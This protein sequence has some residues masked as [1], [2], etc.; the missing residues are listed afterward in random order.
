VIVVNKW[1][2]LKGTGTSTTE[3]AEKIRAELKFAPYASIVF[4]SARTKQRVVQIMPAVIN[5]YNERNKRISTSQLNDALTRALERRP[6]PVKRG[7]Q[8]R[9]YYATQ[10]AIDP[11]TFALFVNDAKMVHFSFERFIENRL[12]EAF[13]FHGT[14]LNLHFKTRGVRKEELS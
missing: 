7:R 8:L 6:A 14:P 5:A 2:L 1:D 11:P 4:V 3:F 12:R 10:V 13:G 9:I